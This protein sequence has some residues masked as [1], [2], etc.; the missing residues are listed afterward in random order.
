MFAFH[1]SH[2]LVT[3]DIDEYLKRDQAQKTTHAICGEWLVQQIL[4]KL[5]NAMTI[6]NR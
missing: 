5:S 4:C 6:Q 3:S 1:G 2:I